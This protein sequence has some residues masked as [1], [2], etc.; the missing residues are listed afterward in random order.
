ME[1]SLIPLKKSSVG[2]LLPMRKQSHFEGVTKMEGQHFSESHFSLEDIHQQITS[3]RR[4]NRFLKFGLVLCLVIATLPYRAGLHPVTMRAKRFVTEKIEFVRDG[5]TVLSIDVDPIISGLVISD[6]HGEP[7]VFLGERISLGERKLGGS[8]VV[9]NKDGKVVAS[10]DSG[11]YGG[12]VW[13]MGEKGT[14]MATMGATPFGGM[15]VLY[16][17]KGRRIWRSP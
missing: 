2:S 7:L 12:E 5:E 8:I 13:V 3:L 1:R 14:L 4:E 15:I 6:K 17:G 9:H 10:I 16:D 11:L